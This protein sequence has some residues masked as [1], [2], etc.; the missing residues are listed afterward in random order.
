MKT[1]KIEI[2]HVFGTKGSTWYRISYRGKCLKSVVRNMS[3]NAALDEARAW[4]HANG[5][6]HTK[7]E[8]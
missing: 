6:T 4:A 5:Y 1:A 7:V 8:A 3:R 2:G